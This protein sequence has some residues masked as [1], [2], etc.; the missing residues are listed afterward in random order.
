MG[1]ENTRLDFLAWL[2]FDRKNNFAQFYLVKKVNFRQ[3]RVFPAL[4]MRTRIL[5][6]QS[7]I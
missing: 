1:F 7:L 3:K 5:K 6:F 4:N 2:I